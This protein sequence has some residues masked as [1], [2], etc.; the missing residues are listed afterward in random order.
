METIKKFPVSPESEW[1]FQIE[2]V[3]NLPLP[4]KFFSSVFSRSYLLDDWWGVKDPPVTRPRQK[5][6]FS[7]CR[8]TDVPHVN[9]IEMGRN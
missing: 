7:M 3:A 8:I 6:V 1:T 2:I 9:W 5:G 4:S